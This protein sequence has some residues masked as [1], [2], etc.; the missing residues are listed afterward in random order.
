M[1]GRGTTNP[2]RDKEAT[3]HGRLKRGRLI[4]VATV[5]FVALGGGAY[6]LAAS[7][8]RFIGSHGNINTCVPPRGGEVNVWKPGHRCSGGRVGLAFP[9]TG[10]QGTP[11][12]AGVTGAAGATGTTGAT[13]ATNPSATTVD[14]E[15]LTKLTLKVATPT[16]GST[17]Q[18]LYNGSA[19]SNGLVISATCSNTGVASVVANGP[20]SA[21]SNLAISGFASGGTNAFGS[22]TATLGPASNAALGPAG[23][24]ESSFSYST[25]GANVVTGQI[26]YQSTPS[27]GS[28]AGCTFSG[29][30]VSG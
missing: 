4:G 18:T 6:A 2:I 29:T 16:T 26:G 25:S 21:D 3:M 8:S 7:S 15:T 14:G 9:T 17:T 30:V 13:G 19:A 20:A 5:L 27:S 24:G 23:S 22:Q 11:G 12:A 28:F 1:S 10:P